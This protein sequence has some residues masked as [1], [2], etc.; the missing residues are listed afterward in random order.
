M[1]K[2]AARTHFRALRAE[3]DPERRR[4]EALGITSVLLSWLGEERKRTL[5]SVLSFGTEPDTAALLETLHGLGHRI[6]VPICEPGRQ[7][8]W[9]DWYPAVPMARATVAP[10]DEPV[11]E[12]HGVEVMDDVDVVLVPAQVVDPAGGRLGQGGGYYDRFIASLAT[13]PTRPVLLA[14]VYEHE[15]VPE[16]SF[17]V[18]ELDQPVDG[19]ITAAGI[20]WIGPQRT[21]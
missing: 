17:E 9:A 8:S 16:G 14:M 18:G 19:V 4:Q 13:R 15:L 11:G 12:R 1:S 10:I 3:M 21:V 20:S 6:L 2:A 7:L 5:T